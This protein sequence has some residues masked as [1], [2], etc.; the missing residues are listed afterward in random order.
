MSILPIYIYGQS[1]LRKKAR[2]VRKP[3]EELAE[4]AGDMVETMRKANGIGLA[5]NQVG[6]LRR[7]IVV[8]AGA[9]AESAEIPAIA[10]VNPEVV[11]REGSW[12]MEEGCLSIPGIREEV[13]RAEKIR[14]R[15]MDPGLH[16]RELEADGLLGR[17]ILHEIDHLDGVLFL[18]HIGT[19][20]RKLLRGRLN[21]LE[22]GEVD[23]D[24]P[25]VGFNPPST[26][27][28]PR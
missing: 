7:L 18:D 1:V 9:I 25:I 19:V 8:D 12:P 4:F 2:P 15:F 24:Y 3:T 20:K 27:S 17:V 22:R 5:A 13:V 26:G 6:D 28:D 16:E 10:M 14:V 21:K 23:V 11:E